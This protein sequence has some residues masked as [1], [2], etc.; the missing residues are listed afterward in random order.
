MIALKHTA[1]SRIKGTLTF[2]EASKLA[3]GDIVTWLLDEDSLQL[4]EL[5]FILDQFRRHPDC[6]VMFGEIIVGEGGRDVRFLDATIIDTEL[7][8]KFVTAVPRLEIE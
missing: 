5:D 7:G 1:H 3:T 6:N 2:Y 8:T 4:T